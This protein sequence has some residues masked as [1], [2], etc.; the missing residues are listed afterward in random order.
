MTRADKKIDGVVKV[1]E[2]FLWW[3]S[4]KDQHCEGLNATIRIPN[5]PAGLVAFRFDK[6]LTVDGITKSYHIE[7]VKERELIEYSNGLPLLEIHLKQDIEK[8]K[9]KVTHD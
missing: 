7:R 3:E 9:S 4:F 1:Y 8:I 2:F 5:K 6:E